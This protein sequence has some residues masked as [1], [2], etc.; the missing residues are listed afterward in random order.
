[1]MPAAT[2]QIRPTVKQNDSDPRNKSYNCNE[3]KDAADEF[4]RECIALPRG[5]TPGRLGFRRR[6]CRCPS[7]DLLV[8]TVNLFFRRGTEAVSAVGSM[9]SA[10]R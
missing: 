8:R 10:L 5:R 3:T 7:A 1:M 2:F 9:A 6:S 4:E